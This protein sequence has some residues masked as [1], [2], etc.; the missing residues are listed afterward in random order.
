MRAKIRKKVE[1]CEHTT[2][3]FGAN[4]I[5]SFFCFA[6]KEIC[7]IFVLANGID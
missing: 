2:D 4:A 3:Y 1:L 5:F 7:T 6:I